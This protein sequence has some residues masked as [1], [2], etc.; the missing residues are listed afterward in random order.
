MVLN[1]YLQ[2]Y[3][4]EIRL[5]Q[6]HSITI[7]LPPAVFQQLEQIAVVTQQ[8]IEQLVIQSVA[9]NLPPMPTVSSME[10]QREL[11]GFQQQPLE[12]VLQVARSV[13][14]EATGRRQAELLE[15]NQDEPLTAE[16]QQELTELRELA[17]GLMLRK[18]YAWAV[19]KW[20]GYPIPALNSLPVG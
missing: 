10:L 3:I 7:E 8:P 5:M 15:R 18:A 2:L 6:T 12:Q 9:N 16:E 4:L 1:P 19:L 20:R 13:M 11:L 14:D 17:D